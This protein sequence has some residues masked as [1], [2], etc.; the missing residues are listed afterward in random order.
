MPDFLAIKAI[1]PAFLFLGEYERETA[2]G[3]AAPLSLG[4]EA[5]CAAYMMP[6][7]SALSG[8]M[9]GTAC[10]CASDTLYDRL[11]IILICSATL[12]VAEKG[13]PTICAV[14]S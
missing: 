6:V 5:P 1:A 12:L 13:A 8:S 7:P 4:V 2:R 14:L 10:L 11:K 9:L 3:E